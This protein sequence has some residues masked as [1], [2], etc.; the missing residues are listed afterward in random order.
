MR[1]YKLRHELI[2]NI[3]G[4]VLEYDLD[5]IN[6]D[7]EYMHDEDKDLFS[8]F[9]IELKPRLSEIGAILSVDV[10][11]PDG[12]EEWSLCYDRHIIGNVADYIVFMA[13]D[14]NGSSSTTPGTNSGYDW[15]SVNLDKFLGQEGVEAEK[16]ILGLPFYMR[17]CEENGDKVD[18]YILNMNKV[19]EVVPSNAEKTWNDNLKQYYVEFTDNGLLNRIWIEDEESFRAKL[20]LIEQYNL[21]GASYWAKGREPDSIWNVIAEVLNVE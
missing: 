8:R 14:Q 3:V 4:L 12:G 6:I 20:S 1:D 16:I 15:I 17:V 11:A 2:E 19:D 9:I 7:F 5:G 13:Y 21:A 18:K 10:T